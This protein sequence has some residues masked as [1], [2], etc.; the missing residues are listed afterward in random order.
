[1]WVR[2]CVGALLATL[3]AA[4][5]TAA[6]AG[7]PPTWSLDLAEIAVQDTYATG[8][9][10]VPV[11]LQSFKGKT[12]SYREFACAVFEADGSQRIIAIAPASATKLDYTT[13]DPGRPRPPGTAAT[14]ATAL[15]YEEQIIIIDRA[16]VTIELED[17][18]LWKLRDPAHLLSTW[19][20]GDSVTIQP[21]AFYSVVDLTRHEGLEASFVGFDT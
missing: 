2:V 14:A 7:A 18:S 13:L 3:L 17:E 21:G 5:P 1:M 20:L 10:C 9:Q 11:G 15:H 8:A 16:G 12:A 4:I 19:R 6:G